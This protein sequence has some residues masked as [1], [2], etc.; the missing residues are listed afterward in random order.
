MCWLF[1][2]QDM[3]HARLTLRERESPLDLVHLFCDILACKWL[4]SSLLLQ[5]G[6]LLLYT[7]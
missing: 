1:L 5:N 7:V 3:L 4:E 6:F 2:F